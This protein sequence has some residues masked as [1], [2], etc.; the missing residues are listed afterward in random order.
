MV[1]TLTVSERPLTAVA[2]VL[3]GTV[4]SA[5]SLPAMLGPKWFCATVTV[6]W[7]FT[8]AGV[9]PQLKAPLPAGGGAEWPGGEGVDRRVGHAEGGGEGCREHARLAVRGAVE[10]G[11]GERGG[12]A[13]DRVGSAAGRRRHVDAAGHGAAVCGQG[14]GRQRGAARHEDGATGG[15]AI[16]VARLARDHRVAPKRGG[17][18]GPAR[19]R[20]A[21]A[22]VGGRGAPGGEVA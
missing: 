2:V 10:G 17:W 20:E 19:E 13:G 15:L 8:L 12:D 1:A 21:S 18:K 7:P 4:T 9:L 14:D 11:A 16:G 3:D 6:Y 5:V 22:R